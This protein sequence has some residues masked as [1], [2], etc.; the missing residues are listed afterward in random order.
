MTPQIHEAT[1]MSNDVIRYYH[2]NIVEC[3]NIKVFRSLKI[4]FNF[5]IRY[6]YVSKYLMLQPKFNIDLI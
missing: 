4:S 5:F 3:F 1:S 6:E 2:N